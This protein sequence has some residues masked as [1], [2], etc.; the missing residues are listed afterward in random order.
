MGTLPAFSYQLLTP[1]NSWSTHTPLQH[2][3]FERELTLH[4][5]KAFTLQLLTALQ[6]EVDIGY[7]S[8]VGPNDASNL[9]STFQHPHIIDAEL[10]KEHAAGHILGPFH[11]CPLRNLWCSDIGVV[12]KKHNKWRMIMHLSALVGNSINNFISRDSFFLHY[13][14]I[15]DAGRGAA[16]AKVDLKSAFR[17]VPV[18]KEDW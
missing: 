14:S 2:S 8:P 12:P 15:D 7:K 13:T 5:D 1:T 18:H 11:F 16:I 4:P 3:Q 6:H 17:M 10:A 9:P